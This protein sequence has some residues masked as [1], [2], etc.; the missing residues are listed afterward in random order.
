MK[1]KACGKLIPG[2]HGP[3]RCGVPLKNGI[4]Y[5]HLPVETRNPL[6]VITTSWP[7]GCG[8]GALGSACS[9]KGGGFPQAYAAFGYRL[10]KPLEDKGLIERFYE[11]G[12]CRF[13][14]VTAPT[15]R[16]FA[17]ARRRNEAV[18]KAQQKA[19]KP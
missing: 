7:H 6:D 8:V 17:A 1:L 16:E 4:C 5:R 19:G 15:K 10:A 18:W 14:L 12:S 13:R 9:K 11:Q 2:P 3:Q